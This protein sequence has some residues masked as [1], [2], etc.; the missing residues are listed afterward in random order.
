MAGQGSAG[1]DRAVEEWL[2]SQGKGWFV[3]WLVL[4]SDGGER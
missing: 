3:A 4:P 2:R 1:Q